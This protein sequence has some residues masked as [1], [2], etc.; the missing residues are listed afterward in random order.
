MDYT[1][2]YLTLIGS[3]SSVVLGLKKDTPI[4]D[5]D[6]GDSR[7]LYTFLASDGAW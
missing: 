3:A 1:A 7:S 4:A 2:P 5:P 6:P